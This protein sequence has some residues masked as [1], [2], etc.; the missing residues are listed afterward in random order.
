MNLEAQLSKRELE[1]AEV[2]A[3][4]KSKTDAAQKLFISEG[5]LSAHTFNI[6]DK[7]QI[8]SKSEL[9]IWW[10]VKKLGVELK[11][12]PYFRLVSVIIISVCTLLDREVY[13]IRFNRKEDVNI[14]YKIAS[15]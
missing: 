4:T 3:F 6:Y 2:M 1:V 14:C 11:N 5:T 10:F 15:K 13:H 9:V 8:N 7:L 12:I